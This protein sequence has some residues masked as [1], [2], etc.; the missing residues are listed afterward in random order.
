VERTGRRGQR[1]TP[2]ERVYGLSA[3]LAVL[4]N[5]P[6]Q[7]VNIA[8]SA[9]LRRELG[10]VLR[11]AAR[12][13]TAYR[14]LS[15]EELG[16][17]AGS[18]HHEGICVLVHK[19]EPR[20]LAELAHRTEPS[21]LLLALDRVSNPHNIGAMLRSAAFF[22]AKGLVLADESRSLLTPAAVR[23]AEGG[24]EHVPFAQVATLAPALEELRRLGLAIVG[25]DAR[26]PLSL[27]AL[28]W[29]AR[30]VLVLG[31]EDEGLSLVVRKACDQLVHIAG[32]SAM[33]SL[34]VSVAA[35]VLLASYAQREPSI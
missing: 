14:E 13:R 21:G 33:E 28:R 22:G 19:R 31:S 34:N 23:V 8:H 2:T 29:P 25:A 20:P 10:P 26:A 12:R 17:I 4:R 1:S 32:S 6:E 30:V 7:V 16:R 35:G 3:A 24:A 15:D 11:E 9:A 18:L 27:A 5:R